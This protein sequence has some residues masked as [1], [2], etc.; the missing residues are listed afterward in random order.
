VSKIPSDEVCTLK[1]R[2]VLSL[3]KLAVRRLVREAAP[4]GI[5]LTLAACAYQPPGP[6][7]IVLP[8]TG[9]DLAAFQQDD[10]ICRQHAV[11]HTGYTSPGPSSTTGPTGGPALGIGTP[12]S[13]TA[14]TLDPAGTEPPDAAGYLQCMAARG[15]SVQPQ[16]TDADRA[17]AYGYTYGY[18]DAYGYGYGYGYGYPYPFYDGGFYGGFGW[19]G[20]GWGHRGFGHRGFAHGGYGRGGY[21]RGSFAHGG[22]HAGGG[23]R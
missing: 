9:K 17:Y 20:G 10:A 2:D 1:G 18:P 19:Y 12:S 23:R 6:Q 16:A 15:D 8:G 5:A 11:A 22:G 4:L 7:L 13:A 21:G 3:P 14:A